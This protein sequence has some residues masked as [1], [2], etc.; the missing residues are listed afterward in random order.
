MLEDAENGLSTRMLRIVS[1]LRDEW[2]FIEEAIREVTRE[3]EA[4]ARTDA[5]CQRRTVRPRS[6][7]NARS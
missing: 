3:L 6:K 4:I 2:H 7:R 5:T 1:R